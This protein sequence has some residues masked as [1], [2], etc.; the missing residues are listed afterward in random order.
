MLGS[1]LRLKVEYPDYNPQEVR[2]RVDPLKEIRL[3][4]GVF[5]AFIVLS[6]SYVT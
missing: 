5:M 2:C 6:F 1:F 3:V 4:A